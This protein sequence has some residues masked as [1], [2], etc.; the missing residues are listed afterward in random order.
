M[1]ALVLGLDVG[2]QATKAV[3]YDTVSHTVVGRGSS[4]YD[5][6]P[7]TVAGRAEQDP[8]AWLQ[9]WRSSTCLPLRNDSKV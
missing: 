1:A 2:T 3:L 6:L 8:Q 5:I 9:V 4:S 7:T